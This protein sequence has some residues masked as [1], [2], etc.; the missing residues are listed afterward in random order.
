MITD[1]GALGTSVSPA[2]RDVIQAIRVAE[3]RLTAWIDDREIVADT[4]R[5]M[6]RLLSNG[7]Y[8]VFHSG[9]P[10]AHVPSQLRDSGLEA[11]FAEAVPHRDITVPA[12]VL[13]EPVQDADGAVG[14]LVGRDGVRFWAPQS[15]VRAADAMPGD[16]VDLVV[17]S[18]RPALSPGFF[19]VDGSR[20]QVGGAGVLRVYIHIGEVQQAV[21]VWRETL[22]YLER[23]AVR[24]RAKV[25]SA[26]KFY[27]RRDA[28]VVYLNGGQQHIAGE[29]AQHIGHLAGIEPGVSA[30]TEQLCP[31]IATAW[32]PTD[33][34]PGRQGLSFGQHRASV[35]AAAL[36]EAATDP[37]RTEHI[38]VRHFNEAFIDP[39]NPARNRNT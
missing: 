29:L 15:A 1:K 12:R 8:N 23:E 27:P 11:K 38:V 30:F 20:Q 13:S 4:P 2:V 33:T 25:L 5:E 36:V 32:E 7:I 34:H 17:P 6:R 9:Q 28:V 35:L 19:L 16:I 10:D 24:Y 18:V 31:G 26:A 3:N 14:Q 22:C 37:D 39:A 21:A